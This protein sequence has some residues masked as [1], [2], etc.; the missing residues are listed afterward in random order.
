MIL[1]DASQPT[2]IPKR[3]V[4]LVP[5]QTALLHHIDLEAETVGITKFCIHPAEWKKNKTIIGGTKNI[6]IE[7]ITTLDP[8]LIIANKEEN[9]KTQVE[10]LAEKFPVWV[11]DV[12]SL[13]DAYQMM[14]DIGLLTNKT[15]ECDKLIADIKSTFDDLDL[16][17]KKINACYLIW[18]DPY[19]TIGGDTFI[20][21]MMAHC[22]LNNVFKD[23]KRYPVISIKEIIDA[24]SELILLSS[25]PYPF[26]EKHIMELQHSLQGARIRLTDGEMFS[27]YGSHLLHSP[28][29]FNKLLSELQ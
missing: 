3:I 8:D 11:T 17:S 27:W 25:E 16:V 29:Y 19:M 12:N 5:S 6:N 26:A 13:N 15:H 1:K 23:K 21:D 2:Q 9:V 22:G 7:K 24:D 18:K 4:S 14:K 28:H 10:E 20:N